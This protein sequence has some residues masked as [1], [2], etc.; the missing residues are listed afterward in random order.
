M[1]EGEKMILFGLPGTLK[2]ME[3][4]SFPPAPPVVVPTSE[5][6]K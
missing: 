3:E 4:G 1:R 2:R 5:D 6:E